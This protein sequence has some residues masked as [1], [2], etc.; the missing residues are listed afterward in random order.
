M[1]TP[2][3]TSPVTPPSGFRGETLTGDEA[4]RRASL[5]SGPFDARPS[6]LAT[7]VDEDDLVTLVRWA[8]D[9]RT[10]LIPRGGGTGMPGGNLGSG[11]VVDLAH[12]FDRV[13]TVD[14]ET[15][16]IRVGAGAVADRIQDA[17]RPHGLFLPALPASSPWCRIGGVVANNGAGARSF[18]HGS[19]RH[20]V[21]ALEGVDAQGNP[22][23]LGPD[24]DTGPWGEFDPGL[25]AGPD[26]RIAGWP[27]VR[28]NS[29]GYALDRYLPDRDLRQLLIGSEGTLAI[30][31]QVELSLEPIPEARG[32]VLV[33]ARDASELVAF[34]ETA[35]QIGASACEFL[36]RRLLGMCRLHE[37]P[38][39]GALSRGAWAVVLVELE[40]TNDEVEAGLRKLSGIGNARRS[41]GVTTRD[42]DAMDRLWGL[43]HR[44]SPIIAQ[45]AGKG[46]I[47]T[48]FI[49][50]SVVPPEAVGRYIE[51]VEGILEDH[52]FDAVVFGHAGDGNVHVNPL[53]DVDSPDWRER[54]RGTLAD[55]AELVRALGGTLSG[56]HGDGR[57]R[58]PFLQRIWHQTHVEAFR[59]V[60]KY[61]D[62]HGILNPGVILPLPGQDPLE[63]LRPRLRAFP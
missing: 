24:T 12:G 46:R 15:R 42:P 54:V 61:L 7:P 56:E 55:T 23:R 19:I 20:R 52:G 53:V 45:E 21:V 35:R 6:F 25:E 26:G 58:A 44:A 5:V 22:F 59:R 39:L 10:P 14:P 18:R 30:F 3:A 63:G 37:D 29:S 28:K 16:T 17:G 9:S 43:R 1:A 60:K 4:A 33:P 38:E 40:G 50:D 62:P 36:G 49:E 32:L 51:G 31:T 57:I 11:V 34:C 41:H 47:S 2:P 27:L 8:A 48:Q 13:G